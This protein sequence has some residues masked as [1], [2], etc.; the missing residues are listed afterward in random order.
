[1]DYFRKGNEEFEACEERALKKVFAGTRRMGIRYSL[2][3]PVEDIEGNNM[4]HPGLVFNMA[5]GHAP[6]ALLKNRN[7]VSVVLPKFEKIC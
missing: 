4:R 3:V 5:V 7:S 1:M 2:A 6:A